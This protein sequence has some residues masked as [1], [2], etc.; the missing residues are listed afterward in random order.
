M[1]FRPFKIWA[2]HFTTKNRKRTIGLTDFGQGVKVKNIN[3]FAA[4]RRRQWQWL[5]QMVREQFGKAIDEL[6]SVEEQDEALL[7]AGRV[8]GPLLMAKW[9]RAGHLN[10]TNLRALLLGVWT[11]AELPE[12]DVPQ[13]RWV[14]WFR[15]AG[16]LTD[17]KAVRPVTRRRIYRACAPGYVRR[18][19]WTSS[20]KSAEWFAN[21]RARRYGV[22][23]ALYLGQPSPRLAFWQSA[24]SVASAKS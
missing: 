13:K 1:R 14:E 9:H 6:E 22:R 7:L 23:R 8:L 10:Q 3:N 18:L 4:Q 12:S 2:A 17:C 15:A 11:R 21:Y 20:L 24:M 16:F 19:A 5:R